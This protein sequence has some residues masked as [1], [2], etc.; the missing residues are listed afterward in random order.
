MGRKPNWRSQTLCGSER[1]SKMLLSLRDCCDQPWG[2]APLVGVP[3]PSVALDQNFWESSC[4]ETALNQ[5]FSLFRSLK[6]VKIATEWAL[7]RE[8]FT[9]L[10]AGCCVSPH[11]LIVAGAKIAFRLNTFDVSAHNVPIYHRRT[12]KGVSLQSF[13]AA[14]Q[15]F[16]CRARSF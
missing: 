4:T 11:S 2:S 1:P 12:F 6:Q 5:K 8:P 13:P 15:L 16:R 14:A 9:F 7:R 10:G 3:T